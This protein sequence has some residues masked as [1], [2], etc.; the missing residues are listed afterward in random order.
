MASNLNTITVA[1]LLNIIA[2]LEDRVKLLERIMQGQPIAVVRIADA[3]IT[4]AKILSLSADKI[5][6]G[7]LSVTTSIF[8]GDVS[9]GDYIEES[10]GD[11]NIV[12]FK[13]DVAQFLFGQQT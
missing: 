4:N 11:V 10:G 3:S 5:T 2:R 9:S 6:T 7:Q 13:D 1:N 8:I 12:M